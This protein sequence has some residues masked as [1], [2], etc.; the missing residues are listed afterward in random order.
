MAGA[1]A[2]RRAGRTRWRVLRRALVAVGAGLVLA[3]PA[4]GEWRAVASG[5]APVPAGERVLWADGARVVAA[6]AG[7][8]DAVALG[9]LP[10]GRGESVTLAAAGDVVAAVVRDPRSLAG[11]GRLFV[12]G[13]DGA[14]REL[15]GDVGGPPPTPWVPA[16][17]VTAAGVLTLESGTSGVAA[18]LREGPE[19]AEEVALPPGAD[20]AIVA[21]AG[22]L[23]VAPAPDGTLVVFQLGT[24]TEQRQISLGRYEPALSGLAISPEGDVA[25]TVP[26]GDGDDVLL[27]APRG[28]SRVRAIRTGREYSSVATAGGRVA[29][30]GADGLSDGVRVTVVDPTTRR[31]LFRGPPAFDVG[32]LGFDGRVVAFRASDCAVVGTG[33]RRTLP[34]GP[35]VRT[36]VAVTRVSGDVAGAA[37]TVRAAVGSERAARGSASGATGSG[38]AAAAARWA[39]P[40]GWRASTRRRGPAA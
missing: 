21:A 12:A 19:P 22:E 27:W 4:R 33:M 9:R 8:G 34:P 18:L 3:A 17:A 32:G 37:G 39:G 38:G 15:A 31:T 1:A 23:G 2:A 24:G 40:C 14:F 35:C 26:A 36:E 29:F 28:A 6:P 25:A 13:A 16:L 7:G 10:A 20:P 30:V 11:D 5:S